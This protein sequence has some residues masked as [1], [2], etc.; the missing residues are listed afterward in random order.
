MLKLVLVS[1]SILEEIKVKVVTFFSEVPCIS[2]IIGKIQKE[3]NL[4]SRGSQHVKLFKTQKLVFKKFNEIGVY[5][6]KTECLHEY[7]VVHSLA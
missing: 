1:L 7:D 4:N 5:M 6:H 3:K 2:P